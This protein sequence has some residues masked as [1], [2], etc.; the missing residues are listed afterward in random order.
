MRKNGTKKGT[1]VIE[2]VSRENGRD[3][4]EKGRL[5]YWVSWLGQTPRGQK[6]TW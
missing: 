4:K 3:G 1:N 2:T 5:F 6:L